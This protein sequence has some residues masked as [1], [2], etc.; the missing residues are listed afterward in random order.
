MIRP[1]SKEGFSLRFVGNWARLGWVVLAFLLLA[2]VLVSFGPP[3]IQLFKGLQKEVIAA[4]V[5]GFFTIS[6]SVFTVVGGKYYERKVSID[7][8]IRRE[9]IPIY[10]EFIEFVLGLMLSE[11]LGKPYRHTEVLEFFDRFTKKLLIWGSDE[12]VLEW[13]R[14]R[15]MFVSD[16]PDA[17]K[18]LK[19]L[20][21]LFRAIRKDTGHKNRLASSDLL[22]LVINDVDTFL[23]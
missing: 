5:A 23:K 17:R 21:R 6:V 8:E 19:G 2:L 4:I 16:K 11:K 13:S 3:L 15:R 10:E 22:G 12:V 18:T 1:A 9:K 14:Y 7:T 20:D